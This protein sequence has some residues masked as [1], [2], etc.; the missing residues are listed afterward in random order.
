MDEQIIYIIVAFLGGAL[1][2][3][4]G[5]TLV[6]SNRLA[7]LEAN[8]SNLTKALD[9]PISLPET[10]IKEIT[11]VCAKASDLERRVGNL[12]VIITTKAR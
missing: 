4:F 10:I 5:Y 12:E 1:V 9:K 3:S 8:I 7:K 2:S 6:F 11:N